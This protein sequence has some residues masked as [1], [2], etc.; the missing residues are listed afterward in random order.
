MAIFGHAVTVTEPIGFPDQL[1]ALG[2]F[3]TSTS[4]ASWCRPPITP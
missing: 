1:G 2:P 3:K 4:M